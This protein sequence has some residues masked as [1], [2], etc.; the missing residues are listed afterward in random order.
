MKSLY[1][2]LLG[3][4]VCLVLVIFNASNAGQSIDFYDEAL[5]KDI[6]L[7]KSLTCLT[8]GS[9]GKGILVFS[10][11][12]IE[13]NKVKGKITEMSWNSCGW[14][15]FNGTLKK[16]ELFYQAH[17]S[18]NCP[19]LIGNINFFHSEKGAVKAS[20]SWRTTANRYSQ[21]TYECEQ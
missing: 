7:D 18:T 1:S 16:D 2:R 6:L 15:V 5:A 8:E 11:K 14:D 19:T 17:T 13:G 4:A 12:A 10:F 21:R 20:G 9:T 3:I